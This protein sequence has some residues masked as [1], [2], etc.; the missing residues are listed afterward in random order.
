VYFVDR[1]GEKREAK[2]KIGSNLLDVAID[3]SI[4]LEGFG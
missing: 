2:A 4:D 1:D 3:N